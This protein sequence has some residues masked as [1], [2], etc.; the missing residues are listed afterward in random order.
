MADGKKRVKARLVAKGYQDPDI[1]GGIVDTSACVNLRP[2]HLQVTSLRTAKK[3][4]L[5]SLDIK[6]AF[7][8]AGGFTRDVFLQA[9]VAWEP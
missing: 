1:Q 4:N 8:Q 2:P 6:N 5:W 9:P 3:W 7:L